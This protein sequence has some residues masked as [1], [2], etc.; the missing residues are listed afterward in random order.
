MS[1]STDITISDQSGADFLTEINAILAAMAS[2]NSGPSEPGYAVAGMEWIDTSGTPWLH[3]RFDG[4]D[5]IIT[6]SYNATTNKFTPY[7]DG[8]AIGDLAKYGVGDGI[9]AS[10]GNVC[11][12]LD[13]GTLS[14]SGSGIKVTA[15]AIDTAQ[16]A[17]SGVSAGSYTA[18]DITVDAKGRITAA[19]NGSG[20]GS[21]IGQS[22]LDTSLGSVSTTSDGALLTLPGGQYGFYP[23]IKHSSSSG[24]MYAAPGILA[25]HGIGNDAGSYGLVYSAGG[26]TGGFKLITPGTT[27]AARVSM[28]TLS[29]TASAQQ[30]YFNASP[31]FDHGDGETA[32]YIYLLVDRDGRA[33]AHYSADVPPWAYNGPTDIRAAYIDPE[34]GVKYRRKERRAALRQ[35]LRA[36]RQP[37][38]TFRDA[39]AAA[40]DE[41]LARATKKPAQKA[42]MHDPKHS[43]AFLRS[44]REAARR[45]VLEADYEAITM[46]MKM[47]DMALIPHP[48]GTIAPGQ[49]VVLLDAMDERVGKLLD[50]QADGGADEIIE[51]LYSGDL[52]A[53]NEA[54]NRKGPPGVMQAALKYR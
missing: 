12:K 40:L 28:G 29:G 17:D 3:K 9:E 39:Y 10:G 2:G 46:E 41:A 33:L 42:K 30:R 53:D 4:S 43:G 19:A 22:D 16:L 25:A 45:A 24:T 49:T 26:I 34:T 44:C 35:A 51:A 31:P 1:Q 8:A 48:F 15:G 50:H 13:G 38:A 21:S 32:G 5:W 27:Y 11:V 20:G 18:A 37:R 23:Q 47:R 7:V 6:G 54:L 14:R 36:R 52:Y